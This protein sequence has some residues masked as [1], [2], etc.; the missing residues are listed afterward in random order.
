MYLWGRLHTYCFDWLFYHNTIFAMTEVFCY[1][2][3]ISFL[4]LS[5]IGFKMSMKATFFTVA[6]YG[7]LTNINVERVR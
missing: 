1:L 4:W 6:F 7:Y 5:G 3:F 2:E